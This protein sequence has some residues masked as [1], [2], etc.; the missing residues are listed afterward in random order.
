[1]SLYGFQL[2]PQVSQSSL[3]IRLPRKFKT[4]FRWLCSVLRV[5]FL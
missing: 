1:M 3:Y 4:S 2:S 5:W